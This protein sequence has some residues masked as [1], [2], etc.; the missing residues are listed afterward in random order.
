MVMK[1]KLKKIPVLGQLIKALEL[2]K[3]PGANSFSFYDLVEMYLAGLVR[4][5]F[6]ARAGSVSFSFFMALFPFLLF[7]LNL[8]PF[9]PIQNFDV[10]LLEFI[11]ALLPQETH[12][13]FTTIFQDIQSKPRGGLLSS[14]FILSIFLTANGVSSIFASFEE[15]YHVDLTRNFFKQYFIAV[16]VSVLLAFLLLVA[17]AVFIFFE[18]YFLRNLPDFVTNTV[19]WIRIGQLI[20]FV[21]L[22]Y[23]SISTLYFFGTVE[24]RISRF[25]SA[26]AFMTT[27]LL[28]SSTY[29]F[30]VYVDR[31]S[32]YNQLY[33][34]IGALLLF[35]LY[36]W[37][38]SILLLLG[39]ELNAT[40]NKL[41]KKSK[42][43]ISDE[44]S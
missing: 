43:N 20:F 39:F 22:A 37:I 29:L 18:I 25:F 27:L 17:V 14:V 7:V 36:T 23:F 6:T 33:G 32:T 26:G 15:S 13:F 3:L 21:I 2:I 19:N 38:N 24:G 4:G 1:E 8:L 34:S 41:N 35:M 16:G 9:I 5:A 10:V 30:G 11:E 31:F 44:K 28:I 40:L 12:T 42:V